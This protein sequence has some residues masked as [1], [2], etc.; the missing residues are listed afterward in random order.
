MP[1]TAAPVDIQ[2]HPR[3][4]AEVRERLPGAYNALLFPWYRAGGHVVF[5][6]RQ[7]AGFG[8]SLVKHRRG[9]RD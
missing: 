9:P 5:Q 2:G 1:T 8:N 6:R 4:V 7:R 3:A